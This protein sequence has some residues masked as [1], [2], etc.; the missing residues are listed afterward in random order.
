MGKEEDMVVGSES[1]TALVVRRVGEEG[2]LPNGTS[3]LLVY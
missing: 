2:D 1:G 3:V